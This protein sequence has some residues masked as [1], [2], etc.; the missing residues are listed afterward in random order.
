MKEGRHVTIYPKHIKRIR[1][2]YEHPYANKFNYLHKMDKFLKAQIGKVDIRNI[3]S[4]KPY[5][6]KRERS[7]N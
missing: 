5:I 3:K 1:E 4:K 7:W 6:Y 2:H